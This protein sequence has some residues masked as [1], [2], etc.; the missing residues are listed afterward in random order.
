MNVN[1]FL[2]M[3]KK[4]NYVDGITIYYNNN[5]EAFSGIPKDTQVFVHLLPKTINNSYLGNNDTIVIKLN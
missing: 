1:E 4:I 5:E 2:L 3:L